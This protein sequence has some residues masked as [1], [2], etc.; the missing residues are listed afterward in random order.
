M[1]DHVF[2]G[3]SYRVNV[4]TGSSLGN[5]QYAYKANDDFNK[6]QSG[7]LTNSGGDLF[8]KTSPHPLMLAAATDVFSS[9]G[10]DPP[11]KSQIFLQLNPFQTRHLPLRLAGGGVSQRRR[12]HG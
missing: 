8:G 5:P 6:R 3:P 1:Q 11:A 2:F 4:I 9:M 10:K 12:L 7:I